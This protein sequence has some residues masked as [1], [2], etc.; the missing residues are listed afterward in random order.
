VL[1]G[2]YERVHRRVVDRVW[3]VSQSDRRAMRW[4]AGMRSVDVVTLGVDTD[5]FAP[6]PETPVPRTAVFWGRLDFGP[7]V[8]ALQWFCRRVWPLVRR[9]VPDA[10]FTIVGFRPTDAVLDVT[11]IDGVSLAADLAD[12]RPTV[13]RHE[14][15]V[16]PFVSGRGVK[17]KLLE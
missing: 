16:L 2:L 10:R 9:R 11:K 13:R 14:V 7:N 4:L 8:Q 15:A 5:F 17:N 1:K 12:L 3:V 6:G